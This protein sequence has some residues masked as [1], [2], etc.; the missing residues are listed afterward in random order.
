MYVG[1]RSSRGRTCG[2]KLGI[3]VGVRAFSDGA[4]AVH[5]ALVARRFE[6]ALLFAN[7][8][9]AHI[10]QTNAPFRTLSHRRRESEQLFDHFL[11]ERHGQTNYDLVSPSPQ[12]LRPSEKAEILLLVDKE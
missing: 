6:P 9:G 2:S 3:L 10:W 4:R 12:P 11:V 7:T 5:Y 1:V 8:N